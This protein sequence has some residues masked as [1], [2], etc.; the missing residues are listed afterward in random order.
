M[1]NMMNDNFGYDRMV[2]WSTIIS[3][4]QLFDWRISVLIFFS[5]IPLNNTDVDTI[6]IILSS[7]TPSK[8]H[9]Y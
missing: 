9:F 2:A 1:G 8:Y 4:G 6:N 3:E 5:I 7:H